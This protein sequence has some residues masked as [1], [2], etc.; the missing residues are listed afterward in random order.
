MQKLSFLAGHW[1]GE[2]RIYR[3]A[4]TLELQQS[5]RA[6]FKLDG[7]LM[8]IEGIGRNKADGRTVLQALGII[9]FD[10]A[11]SRYQ[12]RAFN[13][14]RYLESEMKLTPDGRGLTWG[15]VLG[16]IR[17]SSLL[18]LDDNGQWSELHEITIGDH[19]PQKLMELAVSRAT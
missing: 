10:D 13:D 4:G 5:E 18:R 16:E 3:G 15:F 19:P 8:L 2:A 7:L 6:E 9:S 14:G 1:S 11:T 12:F 17:T